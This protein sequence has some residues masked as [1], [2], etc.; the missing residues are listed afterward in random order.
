[1]ILVAYG[2]RPEYIKLEPLLYQFK[3]QAVQNIVMF[4]GQHM[5]IVRNDADI[6]VEVNSYQNRLDSIITSVLNK[7]YIF[8]DVGQVLVQGD[9]TSALAVAIAAFDRKI[10]VIHL[11]AGLRTFDIDSPYP[12]EFNRCAIDKI[13]SLHFCATLG[14]RNNL[15]NEGIDPY[16]IFIT[17]NTALDNLTAINPTYD[18]IVFC[19]M[20]RRE[21]HEILNEWFTAISALSDKFTDFLFVLPLHPNPDVKKN[22]KYL[23]HTIKVCDP[24]SHLDA[25]NYIKRSKFIITDSGGVQEEASFFKKRAFICRGITERTECLGINSILCKTPNDLYE[26]FIDNIDNFEID[27]FCPYGDGNASKKIT[28]IIARKYG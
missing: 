18:N 21:N 1:M 27:G 13:A 28:E 22:K 12:E 9:T 16:S 2:T 10:P 26:K 23:S 19:T 5:D 6:Y 20:H 3:V 8:D 25:I 11:E 7:D 15:I 24:L 4:I 14:N 17:G